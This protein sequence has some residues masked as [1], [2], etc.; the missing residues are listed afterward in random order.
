MR[1]SVGECG[2]SDLV[3]GKLVIGSSHQCSERPD[4]LELEGPDTL[5]WF[6]QPTTQAPYWSQ[7][8]TGGA[9]SE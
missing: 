7:D 5:A 1:E 8:L 3:K 4:N 2:V 6:N 9:T